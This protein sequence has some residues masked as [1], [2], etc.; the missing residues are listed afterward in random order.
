[1][2]F[3]CAPSLS[4]AA[5]LYL[6]IVCNILSTPIALY[7][8]DKMLLVAYVERFSNLVDESVDCKELL[9]KVLPTIYYLPVTSNKYI[10]DRLS[11]MLK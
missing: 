4:L 11:V 3:S 5:S 8:A 6:Y 2:Q 10:A 7:S 1:M 9:E